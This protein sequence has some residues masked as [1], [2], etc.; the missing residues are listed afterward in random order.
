MNDRAPGSSL[1]SVESDAP[2][3]VEYHVVAHNGQESLQISNCTSSL[4]L[5]TARNHGHAQVYPR[6]PVA[7]SE[8]RPVRCMRM[9]GKP[10][11]SQ[12]RVGPTLVGTFAISASFQ[13]GTIG[14]ACIQGRAP[15]ET[16]WLGILPPLQASLSQHSGYENN[17]MNLGSDQ[18]LRLPAG[19]CVAYRGVPRLQYLALSFEHWSVHQK[20]RC[21]T[22][23]SGIAWVEVETTATALLLCVFGAWLWEPDS[24]MS[25]LSRI[26]LRIDTRGNELV[27][28]V[29]T[30]SQYTGASFR[31]LG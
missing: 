15:S 13:D 18:F 4:H 25:P 7:I 16:L 26:L 2:G 29:D 12:R 3:D 11:L 20:R 6:T 28:V 21:S 24:S 10:L 1:I 17:L 8:T 19:K 22:R 5:D 14:K 23:W 30:R 27:T 9:H 31:G